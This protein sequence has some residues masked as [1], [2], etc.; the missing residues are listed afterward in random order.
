MKWTPLAL[1]LAAVL[2]SSCLVGEVRPQWTVTVRT[3]AP[4]PLVGD[5]LLVEI[6]DA[7][8]ALACEACGSVRAAPPGTFPFSFGVLPTSRSL[9]VR[10]RLHRARAV[11]GA[12]TPDPD[13]TLDALVLLPPTPGPV[14]VELPMACFGVP[15]QG[16]ASCD[17]ATRSLVAIA[18]APPPSRKLEEGGWALARAGDCDDAR[19]P[20]GMRCAPAGLFFFGSLLDVDEPRDY[21]TYLAPFYL[22]V[23]ELS[24]GR[25]RA[26]ILAGAVAREPD[27]RRVDAHCAYLGAN[28][29]SN[30][31][32]ALNC[33]D[34][35]LAAALCASEGKTLPTEAQ[36]AAAAG[37]GALGTRFPW[38]ESTDICAYAVVA[39]NDDTSKP[40]ECRFAGTSRREPGPAR[41][42]DET[43][44]VT[45]APAAFRHMGGNLDEWVED[46]Y[47][48]M[49]DAYYR[50]AVPLIDPL[51]RSGGS[52]II[53]G[54]SWY[55]NRAFAQSH[56]RTASGFAGT[57]HTGFRCAKAVER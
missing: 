19:A 23:D 37:N 35:A 18:T 24:V 3:D 32:L 36:F 54:G 45:F 6:L 2:G 33:V 48:S 5:R 51:A 10:V 31:D 57:T 25:A 21:L 14:E 20:S 39:R 28:D 8:G 15:S 13:T 42:G 30:D 17:P 55:A 16:D 40:T 29:P 44:D 41:L 9:R 46:T 26:A 53:R 34:R 43:L 49:L 56:W 50:S 1:A 47:L 7:D 52:A 11:R 27:R 4:L 12:G 22:D 38:G